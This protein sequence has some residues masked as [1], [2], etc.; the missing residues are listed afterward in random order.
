MRIRRLS[1]VMLALALTSAA[2]AD[3]IE[4]NS[5]TLLNVGTQTRGGTPGQA[6]DLATTAPAYEIV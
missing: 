6:F 5:T 1:A 4:V 2:R 3:T